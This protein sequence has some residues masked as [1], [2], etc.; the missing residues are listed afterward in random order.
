M[1]TTREI[2]RLA[3]VVPVITIERIE[4]AVPLGCALVAGGL[5]VLEVTLRTPVALQAIRLLAA[6]CEGAVIGAGTLRTPADVEACLEA[7]AVFAV[8]PGASPKLLDAAAATPELPLLPGIATPSE[9]M[10]LAE[11]GYDTLK[12]F[13]AGPAGGPAMLKAMAAPLP[14]LAFCPTGG[15][16]LENAPDYLACPNVITVGGSWVVPNDRIKAGDWAA[17]ETL[18]RDAVEKLG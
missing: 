10:A 2:C 4:D 17:I 15:V 16:N 7:G 12:F 8:S 5:P 11:R 13:P 14:D 6:E 18:A 3:P 1:R 9:A